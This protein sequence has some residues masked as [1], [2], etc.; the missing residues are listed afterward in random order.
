[1][2]TVSNRGRESDGNEAENNLCGVGEHWL[3]GHA[4]AEVAV[5]VQLC[6]A[7]RA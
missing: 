4:G 3:Y 1:M 5:R 7:V 6:Q 2:V